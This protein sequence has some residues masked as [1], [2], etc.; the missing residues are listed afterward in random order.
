MALKCYTR[1]R[2]D[3]SKYTNCEKSKKGK[4]KPGPKKGSTEAKKVM[5]HARAA[6]GPRR[7]G[8]TTHS[9]GHY[10]RMVENKIK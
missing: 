4:S 1:A 10:K 9:P 7:S 8:R 5:A 2:N 6:Q 3:G